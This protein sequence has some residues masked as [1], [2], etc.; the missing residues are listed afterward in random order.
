MRD[1][2]IEDEQQGESTGGKREDHL[3]VPATLV[4]EGS[5]HGAA[6][7]LALEAMGQ[8]IDDPNWAMALRQH[9][10]RNKMEGERSSSLLHRALET[11]DRSKDTTVNPLL[12][13][14]FHCGQAGHEWHGRERRKI[15]GPS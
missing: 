3:E 7:L 6:H 15:R 11:K 14:A 5:Q 10:G 9:G 4:S 2:T 13:T 12:L 8:I 1:N